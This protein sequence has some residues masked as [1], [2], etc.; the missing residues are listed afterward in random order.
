[1]FAP[2]M[3]VKILAILEKPWQPA[4][5][6]HSQIFLADLQQLLLMDALYKIV[7]G[8]KF[9]MKFY[10]KE[11]LFFLHTLQRFC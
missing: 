9:Y 6:L 3:F 10:I 5:K 2:A 11:Q 4:H 8:L 1:M 7:A